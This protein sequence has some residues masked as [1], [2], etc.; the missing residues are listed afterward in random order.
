VKIQY[1]GIARTIESDFRNL[2][3]LMLPARLTKDW[4]SVKDQCEDLQRRLEQETDY[5]R[6]AKNLELARSLFREEDGIV[7]PR[8]YPEWS[9]ARVLT[10]ERLEGVH[11]DEYLA[12]KP[13]QRERNELGRQIL[14]AWYRLLYAGR[15]LYADY[16]PGNFLVLEDGRLGLLGFGFVMNLD[17]EQW[18]MFRK[19]DRPLTTGNREERLA[20]LKEWNDVS[21][22][23]PERLRLNDE[24]CEWFWMARSMGREMDFSDTEDFRRGIDLFSELVRKRYTRGRAESPTLC[25]CQ[26]GWRAILYQLGARIDIQALAEE[27]V[28]ATGW[29]RSEYAG[30]R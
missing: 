30:V 12:R 20:T 9:T 6:E 14:K 3:L 19:M 15:M 7:V 11:I 13:S 4:D 1:P 29:D 24:F 21:D 22:D 28:R 10:M 27:E 25:R 16:H 2:F 26:F 23:E 8:V 17:D 5:V 18:E